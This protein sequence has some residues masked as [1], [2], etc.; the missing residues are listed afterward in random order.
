[1]LDCYDWLRRCRTGAELIATLR[2]FDVEPDLFLV[3]EQKQIGPPRSAFRGP[4]ERCYIYPRAPK[5]QISDKPEDSDD[6]PN[7]LP[8]TGKEIGSKQGNYCQFCRAVLNRAWRYGKVSRHAVILWGFVNQF[9]PQ[10]QDRV[11]LDKVNVLGEYFHD[12]HHFLIV[13]Y[14]KNLMDWMR[15]VVLYY[16]AELK[17]LLQIFPTVGE[18][19]HTMG[20]F[21]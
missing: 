8:D 18:H 3:Q 20:D 12:Q 11:K 9:P 15:E 2:S 5:T 7:N 4:C 21:L 16:G 10:F 14:K 13:L 19:S 6:P 17:G 1:M